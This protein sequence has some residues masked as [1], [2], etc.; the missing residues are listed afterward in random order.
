[1]KN[2]HGARITPVMEDLKKVELMLVRERNAGPHPGKARM[3]A[4]L[5][6]RR[7]ILKKRMDGERM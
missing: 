2:E 7:T 3:I 4:A 6:A 1:M 5:E